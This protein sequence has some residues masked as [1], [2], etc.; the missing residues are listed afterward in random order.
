[1][2]TSYYRV[3]NKYFFKFIMKRKFKTL[4]STIQ[5]M[6]T[7][8][9]SISH[10]NSVSIHIKQT[11]T[12]ASGKPDPGFRQAHK[13]GREKPLNGVQTLP[14]CYYVSRKV[15]EWLMKFIINSLCRLTGHTVVVFWANI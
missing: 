9:T 14:S 13:C 11:T 15:F 12:Y 1:M 10:L 3:C 5:P 6:S 8:R 7:K 4:L 2:M